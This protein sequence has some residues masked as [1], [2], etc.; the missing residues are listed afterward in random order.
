MA[1]P[2]ILGLDEERVPHEPSIH[3]TMDELLAR[4]PSARTPLARRGMACVG[5]PMARFD[6]LDEA[7]AAYALDPG[8]LLSEVTGRANKP[9]GRAAS[10]ASRRSSPLTPTRASF[11]WFGRRGAR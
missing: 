9:S 7:A 8:E 1:R 4:W 6:T 3:T 2:A 5:C 11:T 10:R